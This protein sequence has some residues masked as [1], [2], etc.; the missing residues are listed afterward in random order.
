MPFF[1]LSHGLVGL[2]TQTV[3][4]SFSLTNEFFS[5]DFFTLH[6]K[7]P[8]TLSLSLSVCVWSPMIDS[9]K[10]PRK[11]LFKLFPV[12][13]FPLPPSSTTPRDVRTQSPGL[14]LIDQKKAG[15]QVTKGLQQI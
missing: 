7:N 9:L 15:W 3:L 4:L 11:L 13:H 6:N 8:F 12:L 5:M 14:M 10:E 2:K 1:T